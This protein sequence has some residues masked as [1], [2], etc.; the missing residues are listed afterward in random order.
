FYVSFAGNVTYPTSAA[1]REL[2]QLVPD[3]RLL[4]ETDAPFLAPQPVR[5]RMNEPGYVTHTA[6]ALAE[7]RGVPLDVLAEQTT[8]N[9][10]RLFALP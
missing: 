4:V 8:R 10:K 7:Y 9:A 6:A 3:D 2:V 1:L 5:G